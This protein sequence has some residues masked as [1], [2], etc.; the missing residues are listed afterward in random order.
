[1]VFA[2]VSVFFGAKATQTLAK[3][4]RHKVQGHFYVLVILKFGG[5]CWVVVVFARVAVVFAGLRSFSPGLHWLR[6]FLPGCV[7]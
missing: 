4:T 2:R 5:F 3:T 7:F 1:M 6:W